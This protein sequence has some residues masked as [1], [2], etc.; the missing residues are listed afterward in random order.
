MSAVDLAN[1]DSREYWKAAQE[2]RLVFQKCRAC[3]NVQFPPRH[4]C[5]A[6]WDDELEWTESSGR[7]I[8]ESVTIVR[9]AVVASFRDKVPYAIAAISLEEGPR[10]ITNLV[11]EG[12]LNAAIGDPVK[13]DFVPDDQ[14]N[15]LPQFR[16]A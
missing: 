1:A 14:G 12:A 2:G 11:G 4:H 13:V 9:R 16:T 5:A 8:V 7:G 10:L 15:L 6:C 3:G